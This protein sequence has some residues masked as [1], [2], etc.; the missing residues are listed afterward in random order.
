[1]D[2][3]TNGGSFPILLVQGITVQK[4]MLFCVRTVV[5]RT[6]RPKRYEVTGGWKKLQNEQ[7][8]NL[9]SSPSIIRMIE[10]RR[11]AGAGHVPHMR[12]KRN[13]KIFWWESR[14]GE[15]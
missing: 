11:M 8:P 14:S 4:T 13:A 1:L 7:L 2:E 6:F 9:Y 12:G 10:S 5:K 3:S 15:K